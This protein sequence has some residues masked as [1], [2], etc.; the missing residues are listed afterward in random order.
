MYRLNARHAVFLYGAIQSAIT[1]AAA[2]AIAT[3]QAF[4]LGWQFIGSWSTAWLLAWLAM[5]PLVILIAPAIRW[6]VY[7]VTAA[8]VMGSHPRQNR[9]E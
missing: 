6:V 2:T 3:Y 9:S 8:P 4:G 5:L 1:T 7:V